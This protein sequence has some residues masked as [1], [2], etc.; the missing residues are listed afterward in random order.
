MQYANELIFDIPYAPVY[1]FGMSIGERLDKAMMD[2]GI[3]SQSEL[4]R[5]SSV[6]QPTINRIL[7]NVGKKGPESETVKKLAR[8]LNV[9]FDWLNEGK[10]AQ[11]RNPHQDK[12]ET[13]AAPRKRE[14][15]AD[16]GNVYAWDD[17]EE[18]A[19]DEHR[20]WVD[21]FDY[22]FSAGTGLIQWEVRQ[23]RALPFE[24]SFFKYH[25]VK[26]EH[27]KL[28]VARGDSMEPYL[29]D[30]NVFMIDST[31]TRVRD[32]ERY[33]IYYEDEPLVKVIFKLPGGGLRLHSYNSK[34]PDRDIQGDQLQ[35]IQVIGR[36]IY[37]SG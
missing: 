36:V 12:D 16:L 27:C 30:H 11:A 32:G 13:P 3:T 4:S 34:Y 26:P 2:A 22:H 8:A 23:K 31:D 9:S 10:G 25:G 37:R 15:P 6:P 5:M 14:L 24:M 33:A 18:L 1:S 7:K 17:E 21:R 20:V 28:L 35:Y 19:G 29:F